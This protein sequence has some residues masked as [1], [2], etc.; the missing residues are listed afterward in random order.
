V[1]LE[2]GSKFAFG[3]VADDRRSSA[4]FRLAEQKIDVLLDAG[5]KCAAGE[6]GIRVCREAQGLLSLGLSKVS[7]D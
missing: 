7:T 4:L 3:P 5:G 1:I 6:Y 2:S